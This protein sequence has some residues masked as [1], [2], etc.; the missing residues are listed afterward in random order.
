MHASKR[1]PGVFEVIKAGSEPAVHAVTTLA[2]SRKSRADVVDHR[3]MEVLLMAGIA[4]CRQ[5]HKLTGGGVLVTLLAL[6][7]G[8]GSRQRESV[9]V[10][11]QR[12]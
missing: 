2:G 3:R 10:L 4:R 5:A 6:H 7:Q 9:F 12:F 1:K 11:A 8:V